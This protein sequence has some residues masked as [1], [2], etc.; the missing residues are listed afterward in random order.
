MLDKQRIN[1]D[2]EAR[3]ATE[4]PA[5]ET[6]ATE[7][8]A[9]ETPAPHSERPNQP[10]DFTSVVPMDQMDHATIDSLLDKQRINADFE[11]RQEA[12]Q[13]EREAELKR[14]E[15]PDD[16]DQ[17]PGWGE[18]ILAAGAIAVGLLGQQ[19][20]VMSGLDLPPSA[21]DRE[22]TEVFVQD[23]QNDPDGQWI[24]ALPGQEQ[25]LVQGDLSEP[26]PFVPAGDFDPTDP[27]SWNDL[28]EAVAKALEE[29][30]RLKALGG[31]VRRLDED[32][33]KNK[34]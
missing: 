9:T 2:F 1:A 5:T 29:S 33:D 14:A 11:A 16:G 7:T 12:R 6:P 4:T 19:Y 18:K 34:K 31:P 24:R 23:D 10:I 30:E 25:V 27:N 22:H 3:H 8:P 15:A 28:M 13:A 17:E 21:Q 26:S 32:D 20:A